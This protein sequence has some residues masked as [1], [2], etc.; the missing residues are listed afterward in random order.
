MSWKCPTRV[1]E[2][3]LCVLIKKDGTDTQLLSK[4][5]IFGDPVHSLY[6]PFE[7]WGADLFHTDMKTL[8]WLERSTN[9]V[10]VK[11]W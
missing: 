6:I 3:P 2:K 4:N 11:G 7:D 5:F 10:D 9:T 1:I 8:W